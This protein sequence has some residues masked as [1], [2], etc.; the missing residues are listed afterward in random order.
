MITKNHFTELDYILQ[1]QPRHQAYDSDRQEV[2]MRN[3]FSRVHL[4]IFLPLNAPNHIV[5]Y[6]LFSLIFEVLK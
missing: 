2:S 5:L 1:D 4:P 6:I 3:C